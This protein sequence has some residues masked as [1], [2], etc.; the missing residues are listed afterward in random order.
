MHFQFG[1]SN[2]PHVDKRK[3]GGEDAW[4]ATNDLLIVADG[5]GGWAKEGIDAGEFSKKLVSNM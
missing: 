1:S 3:K 2:I 4:L 5:V